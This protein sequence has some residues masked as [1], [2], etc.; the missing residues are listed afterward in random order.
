MSD[1]ANE[2]LTIPSE[3]ID[4]YF[5]AQEDTNTEEFGDTEPAA[6]DEDSPEDEEDTSDEDP[7]DDEDTEDDDEAGE[8]EEPADT[9]DEDSDDD[10]DEEEEE[11]EDVLAD[12]VSKAERERIE[13]DP[14]LKKIHRQM[15]AAFT[16]K[17]QALAEARR[18]V[19]TAQREQDEFLEKLASEEGAE[20]FLLKVALERFDLLEKVY[21]K[22][23]EL[24]DDEEA[25]S[26]FTSER[27][28]KERE[29][30]V[31]KAEADRAAEAR[32]R[33]TEEVVS[34]M[35]GLAAK[36]GLSDS[37][38][39]VLVE[40]AVAARIRTNYAANGIADITAAELK[41]EVEDVA[42]A[43]RAKEA[44]VR[45]TLEREKKGKAGENVKRLAANSKRGITAPRSSS[46]PGVK[47]KR[48]E[49]APAGVDA[50]SHRIAQLLGTP[51][52]NY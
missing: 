40:K 9:E 51:S 38:D 39:L 44:R 21:E 46:A 47:T 10:S 27:S 41:E 50:T 20:D 17:A 48:P 22:A 25:L 42:R 7:S 2:P 12:K 49:A 18:E 33:R 3:L 26:R 4:K 31:A 52:L 19:E 30:K 28:L 13:G 23:F 37:A 16:Q 11:A 14:A 36:A 15:Q 43:I 32:A 1:V 45:K 35:Q 5:D 24:Q 34:Q 6:D 8:D 29:E